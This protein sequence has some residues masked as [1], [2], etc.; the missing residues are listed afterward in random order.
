MFVERRIGVRD[1]R[2]R[3][4]FPT[5]GGQEVVE[6]AT[7]RLTEIDNGWLSVLAPKERHAFTAAL[8]RFR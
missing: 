5:F 3:R 8:R 1:L 2:Q 6:E 7:E 4:I